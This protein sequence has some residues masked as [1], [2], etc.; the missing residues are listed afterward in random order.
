L[1]AL[2]KH[3]FANEHTFFFKEIPERIQRNESI[4]REWIGSNEPEAIPVPDYEEK[5]NAD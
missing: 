3:K 2:S 5:I 1:K 4:W